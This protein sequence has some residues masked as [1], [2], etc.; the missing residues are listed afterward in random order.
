[1]TYFADLTPYSYHAP[2]PHT[3]NIGWI[4]HAYPYPT[5]VTPPTCIEKLHLFRHY[6]VHNNYFGVYQCS[7]C[8]TH[9]NSGEFRV[10]GQGEIVYATPTMI[11]HYMTQHQYQPPL[12]FVEA[13]MHGP[14]PGMPAYDQRARS[15]PW[16][17]PIIE[18]KPSVAPLPQAWNRLTVREVV[19]RYYHP[20]IMGEPTWES[21]WESRFLQTLQENRRFGDKSAERV[22][23]LLTQDTYKRGDN[24]E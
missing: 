21:A 11:I 15:Y 3:L 9:A 13:V 5:G 16:V 1:M 4:D 20:H 8:H 24:I 6:I 23:K 22:Y 18:P 10:F 17:L 12:A 19:E 2:E 7:L 14:H